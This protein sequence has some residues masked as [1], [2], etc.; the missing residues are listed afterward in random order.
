MRIAVF[1]DVILDKYVF[2]DVDRIS[3]E[4]PIPILKINNIIYKLG[5]AANVASNIRKLTPAVSLF[6]IVGKDAYSYK[7]K[8][9]VNENKIFNNLIY[10]KFPTIVKTRFISRSQQLLRADNEIFFSHKSFNELVKKYSTKN[11]S[12]TIL[13]D[14]NKG[15]LYDPQYLIKN[16]SSIFLVDPKGNFDKYKGAYLLT[17]N[18]QEISNIIGKNLTLQQFKKECFEVKRKLN[19]KYL[20]VKKGEEGAFLFSDN[21][22]YSQFYTSKVEVTD[23]TGAGDTLIA[24]LAYFLSRKK[25]IKYALQKSVN[26]ATFSVTKLGTYAISK[27]DIK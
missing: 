17:P 21:F 6:G 19:I 11:F 18:F 26:A 7:I 8:K 22:K 12:F 4:G 15:T 23:I 10:S 25:N 2:G 20:I 13:S 5:G 14:Y 16:F 9:L 1:G 27:K 3:P 24:T